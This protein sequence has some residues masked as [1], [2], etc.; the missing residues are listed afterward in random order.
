MTS[1]FFIIMG[2]IVKLSVQNLHKNEIISRIQAEVGGKEKFHS[3]HML[4]KEKKLELEKGKLL[5]NM[6]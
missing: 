2:V 3:H 5:F 4:V 6:E 1:P